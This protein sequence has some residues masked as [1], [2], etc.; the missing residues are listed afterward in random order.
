MSAFMD[1]L[2]MNGKYNYV[3]INWKAIQI[4][5]TI[6]SRLVGGWKK[7]KEKANITAADPVSIKARNQAADEA[8]FYFDNKEMLSELQEASGVPMIP[9]GQFVAEDKDELDNWKQEFNRIPEEISYDLAVNQ[10]L[11][12]NGWFDVMK[13]KILHDSAETGLI[14]TYTWMDDNGEI[15]VDWIKSENLIYSYSDFNDF[16]DTMWRGHISSVKLSTIRANYGKQFGGWLTEQ[17]LW[18][19]AGF[20]KD[21]QFYDKLAFNQN[22]TISISRPYDDYNID[23]LNLEYKSLDAKQ[24]TVTKTKAHNSTIIKSGATENVGENQKVIEEKQWNIYKGVYIPSVDT[25]LEWGIKRNMIRPND[26]ASLGDAE[27]S[28][29]LY[30]YENYQM[31]NVAIPEKV[32]EPIEQMILARLRIQQLVAKMSPAGYAIDVDALQELDLGLA[33]MTKPMDAQKIHEQTGRMYY[34]GRDAE[35]NKIPMPIT[36]LA[37]SGFAPQMKALIELYQFHYQVLKDELGDNPSLSQ[38]AIQPRVTQG[39]LQQSLAITNDTTD[40]YYDSYKHVMEET[41]KKVACLLNVS[42]SYGAKKYRTLLKEDEVKGRFFTTNIEMLPNEN[43]IAEF[44]AQ[45]ANAL[46]NNK[47]L[48]LYLDPIRLQRIAKDNVSLAELYFRNAQKR[49]LRTTQE[50]ASKNVEENAKAQQMSLQENAEQE[51]RTKEEE[52]YAKDKQILLQGGIDIQKNGSEIPNDWKT[53][54]Q[55]VLK[56][57]ELKIVAENAEMEAKL[58]AAVQQQQ[59]AVPMEQPIQ[60]QQ[61][62]TA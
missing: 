28:Y 52:S 32:E 22:W 29:S 34:R 16:R 45:I 25:I 37:N 20:S 13:E 55:A 59:G 26:P 27:F 40:H 8:E 3:N 15:H 47:D 33:T 23:V 43:Q 4:V 24:Y 6:I 12:A 41:A 9:Q 44:N 10:V 19:I 60:E 39:N 56:N 11:R 30:M 49:Y 18:Q 35:G 50:I 17:Q 5:G 21:W 46:A 14:G 57:T 2:D 62:Q 54:M 53:V 58:S 36:E 1:R 61:L 42:V 51:R 31:T 7:R 38:E 48:I